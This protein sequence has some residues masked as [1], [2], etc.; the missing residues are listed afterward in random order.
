MK[1]YMLQTFAVFNLGIKILPSATD[2]LLSSSRP[3]IIYI[4]MAWIAASVWSMDHGS[5]AVSFRPDSKNR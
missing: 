4:V 1:V 2:S 3:R 5:D